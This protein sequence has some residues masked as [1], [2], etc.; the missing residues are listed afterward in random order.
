MGEIELRLGMFG[1]GYRHRCE[2]ELRPGMLGA[3][4]TVG[5]GKQAASAAFGVGLFLHCRL[6]LVGMAPSAAV[7]LAQALAW[8][9]AQLGSGR[10]V[11]HRVPGVREWV[12]LAEGSVFW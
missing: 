4:G 9:C 5:Q 11:A 8:C 12:G 10:Q 3:G 2:I 6:T 1:A 7:P